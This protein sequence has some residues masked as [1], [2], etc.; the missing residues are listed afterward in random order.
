MNTLLKQFSPASFAQTEVEREELYG[1]VEGAQGVR[2]GI[3]A[4]PDVSPPL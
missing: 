1:N 3:P 4:V 2:F